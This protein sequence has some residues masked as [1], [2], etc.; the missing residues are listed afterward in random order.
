MR[1]AIITINTARAAGDGTDETG[2]TLANFVSELGAEVAGTDLIPDEQAQIETRLRHWCD[3]AG[4]DLILT[5]GGT[6]F[7]PTDVTPEATRAVIDR[8][9][10][11]I[12]EAMR[13]A[14]SK[15]T[16]NWM[17]SRAVA[18]ARGHTLIINVPGNPDSIRQ[19]S[20]E[21]LAAALPHAL[22][23]LAGDNP[24]DATA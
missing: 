2:P 7:S 8:E 17:L 21:A 3:E 1:T 9:A 13:A 20:D 6:G 10:P 14:W 22:A 24:D 4:V 18:R 23:L 5:G 12:A 19:T 11:G 16:P 15:H